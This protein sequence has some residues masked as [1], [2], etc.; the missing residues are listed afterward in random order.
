MDVLRAPAS[1]S[2]DAMP[3]AASGTIARYD[4]GS[5]PNPPGAAFVVAFDRGARTDWHSHTGG[6]FIYVIDGGGVIATRAGQHSSLRPGDL[7]VVP[8]NEVHWH[9]ALPDVSLNH[10]TLSMGESQPQGRVDDATYSSGVREATES[11]P[12]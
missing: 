3:R 5:F 2:A 1:P 6:Q 7:V 10:L 12:G 8:P 4:Y 9:G 11:G